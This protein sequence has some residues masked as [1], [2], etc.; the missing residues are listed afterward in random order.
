MTA[1]SPGILTRFVADAYYQDEDAY[2]DALAAA[3][4]EDTRRSSAPAFCCRSTAPISA[5]AGT[6]STSI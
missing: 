1:P 5:R 6:T 2:V 4:R 3:M